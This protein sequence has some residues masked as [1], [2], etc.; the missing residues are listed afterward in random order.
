V[1]AGLK[2]ADY[3]VVVLGQGQVPFNKD[4]SKPEK[5][6]TLVSIPSRPLTITVTEPP[7]K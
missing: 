1:Q 6:N 7:K 5:P 2:P 4:A 3:T